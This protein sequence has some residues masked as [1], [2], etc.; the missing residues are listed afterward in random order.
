MPSNGDNSISTI[1]QL[2]KKHVFSCH[3]T[4]LT[5]S[6]ALKDKSLPIILE[7]TPNKVIGHHR[8]I[9]SLANF[10]EIN[11]VRPWLRN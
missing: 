6:H 2:N 7:E 9:M 1:N 8:P 5:T 3:K 10:L 11:M 4:F